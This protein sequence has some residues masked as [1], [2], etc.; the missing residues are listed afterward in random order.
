ML[1]EQPYEICACR[2]PCNYHQFQDVEHFQHPIISQCIL[3][4]YI[5]L[6][7][8]RVHK[9]RNHTGCMYSFGSNFHNSTLCLWDSSRRLC[10]SVL[11]LCSCWAVFHCMNMT[12]CVYSLLLWWTFWLFSLWAI[13]E[14]SFYKHS[15][16]YLLTETNTDF[17]CL[18]SHK[19][20]CWVVG[21][22]YEI[23][24]GRDWIWYWELCFIVSFMGYLFPWVEK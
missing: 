8:F 7:G 23:C 11:V 15:C 24:N 5:L 16:T 20:N 10:L 1:S 3:C 14:Q 19:G 22:S 6:S 4:Q 13:Y 18:Q 17:C 21:Y 9:K 2:Y 12:R